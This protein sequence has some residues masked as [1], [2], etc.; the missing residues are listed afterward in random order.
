M[1][2]GISP[3]LASLCMVSAFGAI[4]ELYQGLLPSRFFTW[5]DILLDG[6]GGVLGMALVWEFSREQD[7]RRWALEDLGTR[8]AFGGLEKD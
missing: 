6:L 3:H 1:S 7:K 4:D 8:H 2:R 5:Y